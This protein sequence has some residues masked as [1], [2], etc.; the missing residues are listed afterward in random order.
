M[1]TPAEITR[2]VEEHDTPR[3]T[4]RS[5][6]AKQVGELA[7]QRAEIAEHLEDVERRLGEILIDAEDVIGIDEL[8]RF[9]DV[10]AADLTR[11][12]AAARSTRKATTKRRRQ[13]ART[14]TSNVQQSDKSLSAANST[15][16]S[17]KPADLP[18]AIS[19]V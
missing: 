16:T 11:W 4:K 12:L 5:I 10:S 18:V 19:A 13:P 9:T 6:A 7:R 3:T 8:A 14:G 2:R 17:P 1:V 15:T